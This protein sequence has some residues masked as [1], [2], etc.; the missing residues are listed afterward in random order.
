MLPT[1]HAVNMRVY[2]SFHFTQ[3]PSCREWINPGLGFLHCWGK[4]I[5][6]PIKGKVQ[7]YWKKKRSPQEAGKLAEIIE[8]KDFVCVS[9]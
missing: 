3:R 8:S 7:D 9:I 5:G 4:M 6:L 2:D 1:D